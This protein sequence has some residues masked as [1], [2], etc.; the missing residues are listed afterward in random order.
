MTTPATKIVIVAGQEFSVPA[1]T[2]N[3]AI[4]Q[5]L[6]SMGFAD[7]ASATIQQGTRDGTATIE[8]VKKAGTKG[9]D[10]TELAALLARLP[11]TSMQAQRGISVA[12]AEALDALARGAL[13][14]ADALARDLPA[15]LCIARDLHDTQTPEE[16]LCT[17]IAATPAVA[18]PG[19]LA[20]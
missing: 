12:D 19:A 1:E 9:L 5:Q 3:E 6:L 14:I 13:T 20:W 15:L 7:V 4:R 10:G 16:Q 17:T 18:A 2:D 11:A 8:F